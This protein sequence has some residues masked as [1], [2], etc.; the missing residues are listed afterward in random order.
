MPVPPLRITK[1]NSAPVRSNGEFVLYWMTSAR[2]LRANFGLQRAAELSRELGKPLVVLEALRCDYQWASDRL[3]AFVLQGMRDNRADFAAKNVTYHP[4]VEP[5]RGA[6][7]GLLLAMGQL[8]AA[9][10]TDEFPCFFLPRMVQAAGALLPVQLEQVDSNGLLP[11]R[12]AEKVFARAV[13]FRRFLQRQLAAHLQDFPTGDPLRAEL[14]ESMPLPAAI[15]RKWP[16]A[17][18]ELLS[19]SAAELSA[20]PIDHSVPPVASVPGGAV[21][22]GALLRQFIQHLER[23]AEDRNDPDAAASSGLSPYLHFGHLSPHQV[24]AALAKHESWTTA[25][26]ATKADGKRGWLGMSAPAEG[27]LDQLITWRELGYNMCWQRND[28]AEYQSLPEWAK[29][30][31]GEC[32]KDARQHVYSLAQFESAMTHDPL[33]NAAQRQ[34]VGEGRIHNYLRMLWGKK[35]VEWTSLPQDA[36]EILIE[37][38]NRYA[39][40]GRNPNSYTGIAWVFGRYDRPWAP[41]REI[42]GLIRWMSSQNTVRKVKTTVYQQRWGG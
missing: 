11:M 16:A 30:T 38:N 24:F 6:G 35:V 2:R 40:D 7:K 41:R 20:L 21:A 14:P 28:F 34:L 23:Y 22:A 3:H 42:F 26:L 36:W 10:V 12:A 33:W 9:V 4:Y 29:Q 25:K 27:F 39:L 13:D 18:T 1:V 37:L 5:Q 8:A 19:G 31:L 17:S 32:A 15:L